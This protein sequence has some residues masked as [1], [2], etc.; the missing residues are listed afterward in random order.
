MEQQIKAIETQYR[1]YRFR[2]RT[3]ARWAIYFDALGVKW[4]YEL[5]GYALS[6][7]DLYLP[8]FYFPR[9]DAFGEVKPSNFEKDS[10]HRDF[11]DE[12]G[13]F[14]LLFVGP[15]S[16]NP[17]FL[18]WREGNNGDVRSA[19]GWAFADEIRGKFGIMYFGNMGSDNHPAVE[20]A[21]SLS[22]QARFE[23]G[24]KNIITPYHHGRFNH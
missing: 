23:H 14:L 7:G 19:E 13:K 20:Y 22:K 9:Y 17:N 1:G 21:L 5:E 12:S 18:F 15:P 16:E 3:E 10:K 8:D 11:V 2:S 24:A 6:S 4:E